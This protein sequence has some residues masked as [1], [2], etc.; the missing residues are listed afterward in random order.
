MRSLL[1][2]Q[3]RE[4]VATPGDSR[5]LAFSLV[6]FEHARDHLE[7]YRALAGGRGGAISLGGIRQ[8]LSDLVRGE[9]AASA[10]AEEAAPREFVVQ[11]VV[12]AYMAVLTWW[13][14][15]GAKPPPMQ[16][17]AMFRRLAIDGILPQP[18]ERRLTI[19]SEVSNR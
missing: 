11:Y 17:D 8:I 7:L 14:D 13:L 15:R 5:S 12:G 18:L 6:M 10:G 16:V 3:Q 4:A 1:A 2:D 9:L 19:A